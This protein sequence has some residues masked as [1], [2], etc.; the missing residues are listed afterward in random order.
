M[1]RPTVHR[2]LTSLA[3]EG[4][5]DRH[6][7]TGNWHLGPELFLLG[8]SAAVRYDIS[9]HARPIVRRLAELTGESAFLSARRGDET[10]CILSEEGSF[11]LRSHVLHEGIRFPLGV[12]SAGLVI[13][14]HLS[15]REVAGFLDQADLSARWG[16]AHA[17]DALR[18]RV[19]ETR[20]AGYAT[21]P[22]LLVEGSWGMAA[23]VFDAEERPAWALSLTGVET[24]FRADRRPDLGQLLLDHAHLLTQ[25]L[26]ASTRSQ[27]TR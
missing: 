19:A 9:H 15:D 21:N 16:E 27:A 26:R 10:V 8:T 18:S 20:E 13:L 7:R 6:S 3:R 12:A 5:V 2:L 4:L 23:A 11:P 1:A 22:G 14:A 17:A 24:R 25:H